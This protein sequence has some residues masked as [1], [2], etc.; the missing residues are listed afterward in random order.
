MIHATNQIR[1]DQT[2][3]GMEQAT[4]LQFCL[5]LRV[6]QEK[7]LTEFIRK[8]FKIKITTSETSNKLGRNCISKNTNE[9]KKE[10]S[11]LFEAL[12]FT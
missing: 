10:N 4:V 9:V 6:C 3:H 7:Q 1:A 8:D 11:T 5:Q 12:A 2:G